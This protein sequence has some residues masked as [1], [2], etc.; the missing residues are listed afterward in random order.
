MLRFSWAIQSSSIHFDVL[1]FAG[2]LVTPLSGL[3]FGP[4]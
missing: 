3:T 2:Y 4:C 1:C